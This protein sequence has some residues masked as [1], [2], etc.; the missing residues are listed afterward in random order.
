MAASD[1]N[2]GHF[3]QAGWWLMAGLKNLGGR[4]GWGEALVFFWKPGPR[5]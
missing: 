3:V 1:R 4:A 5:G 2:S